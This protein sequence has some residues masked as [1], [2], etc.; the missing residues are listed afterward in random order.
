M[1]DTLTVAPSAPESDQA[2]RKRG[3]PTKY[4]P[5]R[6][7]KILS[8]LRAG[9]TRRAASLASGVTYTTFAEWVL[10][11]PDFAEQVE[12]AEGEAESV[13]I[14]NILRAASTGSWQASAWWLERRRHGEWGK[15]QT[16][17][18]IQSVREMARATGQ[19]E[20]AAVQQAQEILRELRAAA[21]A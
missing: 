15:R 7:D 14:Q 11:F 21:R 20:D 10:A 8:L 3:R 17:E 4:T 16:L 1:A 18:V 9:N 5:D 6:V 13:H 12:M 2:P 19:D